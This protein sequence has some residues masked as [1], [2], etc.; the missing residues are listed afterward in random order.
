MAT[1]DKS[2]ESN[3]EMEDKEDLRREMDL[4]TDESSD[5]PLDYVDVWDHQDLPYETFLEKY[6]CARRPVVIRGISSSWPASRQW[7]LHSRDIQKE[8]VPQSQS[9]QAP[10]AAGVCFAEAFPSSSSSSFSQSSTS[11]PSS[12]DSRLQD[13]LLRAALDRSRAK[14]GGR[15]RENFQR[16]SS[17][18]QASDS[19]LPQ[20]PA[21]DAEETAELDSSAL[22]PLT[23]TS[24]SSSLSSPCTCCRC[25]SFFLSPAEAAQF[26]RPNLVRLH[27]AFCAQLGAHSRVALN[28]RG[29]VH[30][31]RRE[32]E[33]SGGSGG[34]TDEQTGAG[35]PQVVDIREG[36]DR[37]GRV[38]TRTADIERLGKSDRRKGGDETK[39]GGREQYRRKGERNGERG[40]TRGTA[41]TRPR[42]IQVPIVT[43]ACTQNGACSCSHSVRPGCQTVEE[44][45]EDYTRHKQG[46][47]G[48]AA[49]IT[50]LATRRSVPLAAFL[51]YWETKRQKESEETEKAG[52][53]EE[54][55]ERE[56]ERRNF[57]QCQP[58]VACW[59]S[60]TDRRT[61]SPDFAPPVSPSASIEK[62]PRSSWSPCSS[63]PTVSRAAE[64]L[65][66]PEEREI[67]TELSR[68][69]SPW[70]L[71]DW[72]FVVEEQ[73]AERKNTADA[74]HEFAG[75]TGTAV[76]QRRHSRV[77]GQSPKER[78]T[79]SPETLD[80][81]IQ[82]GEASVD[83]RRDAAT[84]GKVREDKGDA[85]ARHRGREDRR[86]RI[87][88]PP[89][90]TEGDEESHLY[91]ASQFYHVPLYF[92]DDW[93]LKAPV[94]DREDYRFAYL[95]PRGTCTPWHS[96]VLGTSS[97]S[98][99]VCGVKRWA[100]ERTKR[101]AAFPGPL[102]SSPSLYS[103]PKSKSPV[104]ASPDATSSSPSGPSSAAASLPEG[105]RASRKSTRTAPAQASPCRAC[106]RR[107]PRQQERRP[108]SRDQAS[109]TVCASVPAPMPCSL[110]PQERCASSSLSA[111]PS[112]VLCPRPLD[113]L[114]QF[115]GECVYVPS[116]VHHRVCN[117]TD[118]MAL[119]HNWC[120][121]ANILHVADA[122][123]ED[124]NAVRSFLIEDFPDARL[125]LL[126]LAS[127]SAEMP[128]TVDSP[129]QE[130]EGRQV[131]QSLLSDPCAVGLPAPSVSCPP[132]SS[133]VCSS[134]PCASLA[135][136]SPHS[137]MPS[138][139]AT[140][141]RNLVCEI[142]GRK[143]FPT[144]LEERENAK[145]EEPGDTSDSDARLMGDGGLSGTVGEVVDE[146]ALHTGHESRVY[147]AAHENRGEGKRSNA[148]AT[149][150]QESP[151]EAA[152]CL[153]CGGNTEGGWSSIAPDSCV[154][155][156]T[157]RFLRRRDRVVEEP[158]SETRDQTDRGII[159]RSDR[160]ETTLSRATRS[161]AELVMCE[162]RILSANCGVTFFDFFFFLLNV[163]RAILLPRLKRHIN[164]QSMRDMSRSSRD[165]TTAEDD[166]GSDNVL[167]L[168]ATCSHRRSRL[169]RNG[170]VDSLRLQSASN[171]GECDASEKLP[172]E[173][174][175]RAE[176]RGDEEENG[177]EGEARYGDEVTQRAAGEGET[178]LAGIG[179]KQSEREAK[180]MTERQEKR[181][182]A[183]VDE[184]AIAA[185]AE[186]SRSKGTDMPT[187]AGQP[188]TERDANA[189]LQWTFDILGALRVLL[190]L[191]AMYRE[192]YVAFLTRAQVELR[193][194][195]GKK[196]LKASSAQIESGKLNEVPCWL[197]GDEGDTSLS[198]EVAKERVD[199]LL[200]ASRS[201]RHSG[202]SDEMRA[203]W[204]DGKKESESEEGETT[205]DK[206]LAIE[207]YHLT[208][209]ELLAA[210][211]SLNQVLHA[212]QDG[213]RDR[214]VQCLRRLILEDTESVPSAFE[215]REEEHAGR[216]GEKPS[217]RLQ[218]MAKESREIMCKSG[219]GNEA[220]RRDVR[221]VN[222][223]DLDVS[224]VQLQISES[225]QKLRHQCCQAPYSARSVS[226]GLLPCLSSLGTHEVTT[227]L[228]WEQTRK[229]MQYTEQWVISSPRP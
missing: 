48:S 152:G 24:S 117:V 176:S 129:R 103:S 131:S 58:L 10:A 35:D 200:R 130:Q 77:A 157:H 202:S 9:S 214:T 34:E 99:N 16:R 80:P 120:N 181:N 189:V 213:S 94:R 158:K 194:E 72:H 166:P 134:A 187:T 13:G 18:F 154:C 26:G 101:R 190:L 143:A 204:E 171:E 59:K 49:E 8:D 155:F 226:E 25:S 216:G 167:V 122:L 96:D 43:W 210:V 141:E 215:Q 218:N 186:T 221:L 203:E 63:R 168:S 36:G 169:E 149:V 50:S 32:D 140:L 100:F 197:C 71:A 44:V 105:L 119:N 104:S 147:L 136:G 61:I 208:L 205:H 174:R 180:P 227:E 98:A 184:E 14:R 78:R 12:C 45:S 107:H 222:K 161:Y 81:E 91:F 183:T 88:S 138:G 211:L 207:D 67:A 118:C 108:L 151:S 56:W 121:A 173:E 69:P 160:A 7:V 60:G 109:G 145:K 57:R 156:P 191:R 76:P 93:F 15:Q 148:T 193:K 87:A 64:W 21:W 228:L 27:D 83:P 125:V 23:E 11:E 1:A 2:V 22:S 5:D 115:P 137:E 51:H 133:P 70:Y 178:G 201:V 53:A 40:E 39:E 114:M 225:M 54:P 47:E 112:L 212:R 113:V 126:S 219:N 110:H 179:R 95:G 123:K 185:K 55:C 170:V 20:V 127:P 172:S 162:E 116:H 65:L 29:E 153:R 177:Q 159:Q 175:R 33:E 74:S 224:P 31:Q 223:V 192:G 19:T 209:Q 86:L 79:E 135:F 164:L 182:Q 75:D 124:L 66:S 102:R 199:F 106:G 4:E 132:A 92:E 144:S 206:F 97:W 188:E 46:H 165:A 28:E 128:Q 150:R 73:K 3:G 163:A 41:A 85:E 198:S 68:S 82:E 30:A 90:K 139:V 89:R 217:C 6:L 17:A 42:S 196:Q 229:Q 84:F 220:E 111:T 195:N 52:D 38:T 146:F 37:L 62:P 142:C